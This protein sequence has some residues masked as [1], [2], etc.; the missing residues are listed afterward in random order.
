LRAG[1]PVHDLRDQGHIVVDGHAFTTVFGQSTGAF[2]S[3]VVTAVAFTG[4]IAAVVAVAP[5]PES[6]PKWMRHFL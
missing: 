6:T 5:F 2:R 4:A 3:L 1:G